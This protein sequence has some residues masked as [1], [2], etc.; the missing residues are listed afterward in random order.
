M[1]ASSELRSSLKFS[2]SDHRNEKYKGINLFSRACSRSN[3]TLRRIA[4]ADFTS[5]ELSTSDRP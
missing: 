1:P 5:R 2:V 4:N 3:I